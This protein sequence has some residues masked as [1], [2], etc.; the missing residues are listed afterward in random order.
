MSDS[1]AAADGALPDELT[2]TNVGALKALSNP[3]RLALLEAMGCQPR[4]VKQLAAEL[5][6]SQTKL[7]RHVQILLANGLVK[8]VGSRLVSGI[9]EKSYQAAA[10]AFAVDRRLLPRATS[11]AEERVD[12]LL[13][14]ILD[15]TRA[16]IREATRDGTIELARK[17]PGAHALL[18]LRAHMS[19]TRE[20]AAELQ[21]SLMETVQ[22]LA[23]CNTEA[24]GRS[25]RAKRAGCRPESD[26]HPYAMS[27]TFYP[28]SPS[29]RRPSARRGRART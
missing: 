13:G 9:E 24:S 20:Q 27:L 21:R 8:V 11:A 25:S 23:G 7:Y 12:V 26:R 5:A 17:P 16:E 4:T 22:R 15:T 28:V 18:A 29:R 10:R 2:V 6:Q 3:L 1:E 19:L 14:T